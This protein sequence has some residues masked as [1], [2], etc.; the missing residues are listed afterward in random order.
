MPRRTGEAHAAVV[1]GTDGCGGHVVAAAYPGRVS[2]TGDLTDRLRDRGFRVTRPR[3]AVWLALMDADDH[4]TVEEVAA[5]VTERHP[6]VNLAS[7]YRSLALFAQLDLVRESRLGD[8]DVT[9]W[10]LAHPDELFHLVC[11]SCGR[12]DHHAGDLVARIVEHLR[13]GHGFDATSVELSV[14]GT[15]AD[16]RSASER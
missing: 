16:C 6:G 5:R 8:E 11:D 1:R 15:C 2:S 3:Q 14:V 13:G 12:V 9:R 10:E 7:V 4:L